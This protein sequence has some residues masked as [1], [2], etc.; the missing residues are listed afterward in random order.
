[1]SE[2]LPQEKEPLPYNPLVMED[3]WRRGQVLPLAES[4][5][6]KSQF[7]ALP[8]LADALEEQGCTDSNILSHLRNNTCPHHKGCWAL[9]LV[10]GGDHE[11]E[12][13]IEVIRDQML[14]YAK[15]F[16]R[17]LDLSTVEL[18]ERTKEQKKEFIRLLIIDKKLT[19]EE[20]YQACKKEFH[21]Y[22]YQ[23]ERSLDE[24]IDPEQEERNPQTQG[25]YAV[26]TR[27]TQEADPQNADRSANWLRDNEIKTE[28]LR[29]CLVHNL[30]FHEENSQRPNETQ[31]HLD[32]GHT[33]TKC[34]GSRD[35][36]GN[37]PRVSGNFFSRR[38]YVIWD[39]SSFRD[40]AH[41]ARSVVSLPAKLSKA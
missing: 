12:S 26:W 14:L 6:E 27:D 4:I 17:E 16:K 29:E 40:A 30:K 38:I 2:T 9:G 18:P 8:I 32:S 13:S 36:D 7:E 34:S 21:C 28:T 31:R 1:M 35:V 25:S 23:E 37:V 15:H 33:Y 24:L 39:G 19:T 20:A 5:Y 3:E 10:L 22:H 11:L 41:R